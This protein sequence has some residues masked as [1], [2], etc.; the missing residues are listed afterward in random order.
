MKREVRSTRCSRPLKADPKRKLRLQDMI[1]GHR[2]PN[3]PE[4]VEVRL[5]L[6]SLSVPQLLILAH[7]Q[8]ARRLLARS[9][10]N[11]GSITMSH[12]AA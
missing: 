8:R 10:S 6:D 1:D 2:W 5:R 4:A 12:I 11:P 3:R 9:A 7:R